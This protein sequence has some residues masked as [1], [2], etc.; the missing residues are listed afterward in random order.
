VFFANRA[1]EQQRAEEAALWAGVPLDANG[2]LTRDANGNLI[3]GVLLD[4]NG[5]PLR[6]NDGNMFA[7]NP[8]AT[9]FIATAAAARENYGS[10]SFARIAATALSGAAGGNVTGSLGSFAQ[11][12]AVNALQSLAVN[13]VKAIADSFLDA[14]RQ[15]T[16]QSEA[17]RTALQA[18]VG[19]A[20]AAPTGNCASG[21]LGASC[22]ALWRV[23]GS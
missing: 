15:P 21:A 7:A 4:P 20:G 1:A 8:A 22:A 2:N 19:C 14:N 23:G 6:D 16:V 18:L 12:A 11:A 17:V 3:A 10:G 5:R 13:R 9:A